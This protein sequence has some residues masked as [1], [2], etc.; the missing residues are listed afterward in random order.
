MVAAGGGVACLGWPGDAALVSGPLGD[1]GP[2]SVAAGTGRDSDGGGVHGDDTAGRG[3]RGEALAG[4]ELAAELAGLA[5]P[6]T[7]QH[8]YQA[9]CALPHA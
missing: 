7:I 9:I 3:G 1:D 2:E 4:G 5:E 6:S 8:A